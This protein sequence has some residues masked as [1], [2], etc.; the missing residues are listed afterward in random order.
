M[1]NAY[2]YRPQ[3]TQNTIGPDPS[4]PKPSAHTGYVCPRCHLE[5]EECV[6]CPGCAA[7]EESLG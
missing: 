3:Y 6:P 2:T 5:T 1:A 4:E 7:T